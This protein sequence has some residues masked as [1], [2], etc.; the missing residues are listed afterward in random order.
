MLNSKPKRYH[1]NNVSKICTT[2][3]LEQIFIKLISKII[4]KN[5][6]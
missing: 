1:T 4:I 5:I 3:D 6:S 2:Y